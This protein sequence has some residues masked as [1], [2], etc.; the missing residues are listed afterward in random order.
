MNLIT[1]LI[2]TGVFF[3]LTANLLKK[4]TKT[5]YIGFYLVILG[6]LL[7]NSS[8]YYQKLDP[9][10]KFY[11]D[12]FQRGVISTAI[13]I[14]VMYLGVFTKH[15]DITKRLS[16][17]R[18]E[19]SIIACLMALTHNIL[20]GVRYFV[21]FFKNPE[22]M[23][24]QVKVASIISIMLITLM[25][26]LFITSFKCVRKKMRAKN[27]KRLQRFSYLFYMLIY[28]HVM[29]LFSMDVEKNKFS[30]VVYTLVYVTYLVLRLRKYALSGIRE[31]K[32]IIKAKEPA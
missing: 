27:W 4:Y 30:I 25:I 28:I 13:F 32:R 22:L 7:I 15:N 14:I 11:V 23:P 10:L 16:R 9:V 24:L 1:A 29:V 12:L 6:M 18:G 5:F 19:I 31:E 21:N 20:Y 17:I 8:G 26:P 2:I 3:Y